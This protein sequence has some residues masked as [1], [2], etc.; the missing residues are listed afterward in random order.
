MSCRPRRPS[1]TLRPR[2]FIWLLIT[3]AL[4]LLTVPSPARGQPLD[5]DPDIGWQWPLDPRPPVERG[6]I[7]PAAPWGPGH[8]GVDLAATAGQPVRSVAD[9]TVVFA[10]VIAGVGVVSVSHGAL[11]ST[12]QPVVAGVHRGDL[13]STGSVIGRVSVVGSHC[14]PAACL[15]LGAKRG[16]AYL[17]PL[18]LLGPRSVRLKPLGYEPATDLDRPLA[19]SAGSKSGA[20]MGLSI[21]RA[22]S[23]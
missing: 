5:T 12:Y 8:R 9:G 18:S 20:W 1:S 13:V 22:Q 4:M 2:G 15:H 23:L 14:L 11:R 16:S 7:R 3:T 6:F 19:A 21:G 10:G 17:D